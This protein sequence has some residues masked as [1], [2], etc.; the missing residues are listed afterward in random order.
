MWGPLRDSRVDMFGVRHQN[1]LWNLAQV[2]QPR[3][4]AFHTR[5]YPFD[6]I[7]RKLEPG[8]YTDSSWPTVVSSAVAA[9]PSAHGDATPCQ[10]ALADQNWRAA[11]PDFLSQCS[12]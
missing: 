9:T 7:R 11:K 8:S 5:A 12:V 2:H 3:Q 6:I 4:R 1:Q 10:L